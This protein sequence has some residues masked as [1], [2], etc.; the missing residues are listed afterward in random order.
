MSLTRDF[1]VKEGLQVQGTTQ[2]A[3]T[4]SGALLVAGGAGIGGNINIGGSIKRTGNITGGTFAKGAQ[5]S[6]DDGTFTDSLTSGRV[7]WGVTNYFGSSVLDTVSLNATYTNATSIYIKGAPTAG[8]NLTIEKSWA[9]YANSGSFYIGEL[10]GSTSSA[11]NQALQVAGGI[12]FGNGIYGG[13]GGS[14][15]GYYE[16]NSSEVLTRANANLGLIEFPNGLQITTSTQSYSTTTGALIVNKGGGAGVGGNIYVGGY[17]AVL[18]TAT[19]LGTENAVST[20]TGALRL[21]GG[22]GI[23]QDL[24]ARNGFFISGAANTAT[25]AGNSIQ[26]GNNGGLGVAGSA[27]IEGQLYV[28]NAT[29]SSQLG[30]GALVVRGGTSIE[31]KLNVASVHV[32]DTTA[33]TT[34]SNAALVV[35]GGL[36]VAG[37][38][39]IGNTDSSTGTTATN[40]LVVEGGTYIKRDLTVDGSTIIKG[41]LLLLGTGTQV[42]VNSTNTYIVDP[43]IDIGG[44]INGSMLTV[45][46]IYDKGIL[47]HYQT[48]ATTATDYRAFYGLENTTQRFIFKQNIIPGIDG[49]TP[50]GDFYNSGTWSTIEAGSLILKDS[51]DANNVS[52]GALVVTGGIASSGKSIFAN[53]TTFTSSTFNTQGMSNNAL[54]VPTGGIGAAYLY[55]TN[56]GWINGSQIL[57]TGTVNNGIGGIFTNTFQFTNLTQSTGTNT[58]ALTI[59]GGLGV[60]GNVYIGGNEVLYGTLNITNTT[61]S[62]NTTSGALVVAGGAGFGKNVNVG[63]TFRVTDATDSTATNNGSVVLNG[64]VGIAKS[65]T[66]GGNISVANTVTTVDLRVTGTTDSSSKTT[67]AAT[68]AGGL[69]VAETI[70]A[71]RIISGTASINSGTSSTSTATGDLVVVG[72]VGIGQDIYVGGNAQ[73]LSTVTSNSTLTGALVVTGGVGIGNDLVVGGSITRSGTVTKNVINSLGAGLVLSTATFIDLQSTGSLNSVASIYSLGRPTITATQNP[74]WADAATLYI[75][76]APAFT[77]GDATNKWSLFVANGNVKINTTTVNNQNT[78][79]GALVVA[80]GIGAAGNIT[81]GAQVKGLTVRVDDNLISSPKVTGKADSTP[82]TIDSYGAAIF[83]TAKYLVQIVDLGTPNKFHVVELVVTYDG[84]SGAPGTYISQYGLITNT[85]ELGAFDVT[86]SGGTLSVVFTPNYTPVSMSL[87]AI[88]LAI[89]T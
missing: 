89:I 86:Y 84:T 54:Q 52:S 81:S 2:S 44:G 38:V 62:D 11:N 36:G 65:L 76:N 21:V 58:G 43:L 15:F 8:S 24:W 80:G 9:L 35:D 66:V 75:D 53:T 49:S 46:D 85:G 26:I 56:E 10:S 79:S 28:A 19:V 12:S 39:I 82:V 33:A 4:S 30:R 34:P 51:T 72:G 27:R 14:L 1:V 61:Q 29:A 71:S 40:S 42:S 23:G 78:T 25:I 45:P 60:G 50:F 18:T 87:R 5:L 16:I 68:I 70:R 20:T 41:D 59:S 47:I 63:G 73:I 67:G 64:G 31:G 55:V 17:L 69:G 37:N 3:L 22:L 32:N 7:T 6:L 77:N 13:G 74:T 88:R 83:T 48:A 57:T